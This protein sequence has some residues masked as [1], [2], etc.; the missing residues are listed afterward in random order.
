M[1]SVTITSDFADINCET[2]DMVNVVEGDSIQLIIFGPDGP[3]TG[4]DAPGGGNGGGGN[5][6]GGMGGGDIDFPTVRTCGDPVDLSVDLTTGG[7]GLMVTFTDINGNDLG[8]GT[9]IQLTNNDSDTIIV[10]AVNA[11]GCMAMDT[12]VIINSQVDAAIDAGADGLSF[13]SSTDTSV[14]V[15]N[16]NPMDM[17][18]YAWT[19]NDII[20]GPLDMA[21]V[22]ITSPSEGSV[23]LSVLVTNQFGCDT[24]ITVTIMDIPFMPNMFPDTVAPCF[25]ETFTIIGG[26]AV[27][28][29]TYEYNSSQNLILDDPANPVGNFTV[30]NTITVT[31]TDPATGCQ[32]VQ[33][34]F[35]DV[36]PEISFMAMPSDTAVCEPTMVTVTG[37]TVNENAVI[38]WYSDAELTMEIAQGP[39]VTIDAAEVG[40]TY[41]VFGQAVDPTTDCDQVIP[42]TVT[43]SEIST[44]LPLASLSAC[45]N[46]DSPSIFG[47]DGPADGL[48]YEVTPADAVTTTAEGDIL[49]TGEGDQDLT[50]TV[51]D[52]ST[53]CTTM[54]TV[55]ATF[56]N[57][58]DIT[59]SAEPA[60]I[61][62]GDNSVLTVTGCE[63]DDC[64][65]TW[66]VPTGT[67]TPDNTA[68]V[69]ATPDEVG[70]FIYEVD[71]TS[72]GC[73]AMV[74]IELTVEDPLCENDRVY[75]PNAFSPNGD[76]VNDVMMVRS[77]FA[78]LITEFRFI[79]YDR[80][81]QEV[82]NSEDIFESWNGTQEGDDLEPDVY[83]YW[84]RT[85][86]PSGEELI[87][88]GNITLLR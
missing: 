29:Y 54:A 8:D 59:G 13:C 81:G 41:T 45:S 83:G 39:T 73:M 42:V 86:C 68:Q 19:P 32:S 27:P 63:A 60:M 37:S 47:D 71:V 28:G 14:T 76:N 49:F 82:Y 40:Q 55:A 5:G 85:V 30:D 1:Y 25:A 50:V 10:S 78:N 61:F 56:T 31:I 67:I 80:W 77:N 44:G 75:V 24:T 12:V 38:T 84:L 7:D 9:G 65:Y 88:Q 35:V 22:Q 74:D 70:T 66:G 15:I 46:T 11:D 69:T 52:P 62:L 2:V 72:R 58:D 6:G 20:T 48:V 57:V 33:D 53:G 87:Q 26:E 18:T 4:P 16:N 36:A 51:T 64:G 21:T 3:L 43:V 79:I 23:E 17:L 34:I